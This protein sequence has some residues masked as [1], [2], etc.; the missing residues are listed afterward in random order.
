MLGVFWCEM[1]F[2]VDVVNGEMVRCHFSEHSLS[3]FQLF[4]VFLTAL[5]FFIAALVDGYL[6]LLF[7]FKKSMPTVRAVKFRVLTIF[8]ESF[9][10]RECMSANLTFE[11]RTPFA[12]VVVDI[13]M[14]RCAIWT[15]DNIG[16]DILSLFGINRLKRLTMFFLVLLKNYLVLFRRFFFTSGFSSSGSSVST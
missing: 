1:I 9:M 5:T 10:H 14:R 11:L 6:L 12:V 3:R 4:E 13:L 8:S 7:P 15:G 2:P 16:D